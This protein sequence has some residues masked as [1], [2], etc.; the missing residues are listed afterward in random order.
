MTTRSV[1]RLHIRSTIPH[2]V[3]EEAEA[4]CLESDWAGMGWGIWDETPTGLSWPQYADR[5]TADD[6]G[7]NPSVRMF[8]D[9]VDIGALIWTRS[10]DGVYW[11][12]EVTGEWEYHGDGT[13]KALD[14]FNRRR[15]TWVRVGEEDAVPGK[16]VANFR[17]SKTLNPIAD[18]AAVRFS[19]TLF[20]DPTGAAEERSAPTVQEVVCTLLGAEDLEDL[21]AAYLQDR[22]DLVLVARG[23]STPGYEY[24]LRSKSSGRKVVCSVKS[25]NSSVEMNRLPLSADVDVY[26]YGKS[27]SGATRDDITWIDPTDLVTFVEE[28]PEV[29]PDQV[30]YWLGTQ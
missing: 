19:H 3:Q 15:C 6:G 10:K 27:G 21:V 18:E 7:V 9:R 17:A 25:G 13:A 5:K 14:Q 11:L 2:V 8:H 29:L 24:V 20:G 30:H 26:A 4:F 28:R 12:G 22:Y 23:S 1:F 16:I